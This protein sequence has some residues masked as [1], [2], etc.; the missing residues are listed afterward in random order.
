M[1]ELGYLLHALLCKK[2]PVLTGWVEEEKN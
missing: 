1:L 2:K